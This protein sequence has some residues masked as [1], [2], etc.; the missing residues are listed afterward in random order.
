MKEKEKESVKT[1]VISEKSGKKKASAHSAEN[2][3]FQGKGF[4]KSTMRLPLK[5]AEHARKYSKRWRQDNQLC[6]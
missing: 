6:L 4:V 2:Q 1:A 5:N 3:H